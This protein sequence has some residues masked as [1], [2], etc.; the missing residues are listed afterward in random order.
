M[1]ESMRADLR[2]IGV[3]GEIVFPTGASAELDE[4][5]SVRIEEGADG[6]LLP[7]S[8]LSARYSVALANDSG[9]WREGGSVR[10]TRPIVGSTVKL[11]LNTLP[12][13][14]FF[15]IVLVPSL[16]FMTSGPLHYKLY[17]DCGVKAC[18]TFL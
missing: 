5:I 10:G 11:F 4:V 1:N 8:V 7:G 14:K 6:A 13:V 15:S 16:F 3:T 17:N 2:A 18:M 9:Q 12:M